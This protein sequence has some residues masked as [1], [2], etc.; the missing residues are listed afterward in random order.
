M[1]VFKNIN[2][3]EVPPIDGSIEKTMGQLYPYLFS[4]HWVPGTEEKP[5]TSSVYGKRGPFDDMDYFKDYINGL[6]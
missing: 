1:I 5:Y 6:Q 4:Q 3:A 2:L